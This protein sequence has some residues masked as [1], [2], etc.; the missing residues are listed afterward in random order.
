M[1][2]AYRLNRDA[3]NAEAL[4]GRDLRDVMTVPT[5]ELSK[6]FW[7]DDPR[8]PAKAPKGRQVQVIVMRMRDQDRVHIDVLD[9]VGDGRRMA[10]EQPK[11]IDHQRVGENADAIHL[12]EDSR[13]SEVTQ[14]RKHRPS[15]TRE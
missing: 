8:P 1:F 2:G 13:V 15:L 4:V 3:A 6:S 10:V 14:M 9:E 11:P 12:D 7:H 5:H